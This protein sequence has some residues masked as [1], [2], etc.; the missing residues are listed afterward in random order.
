ME[1]TQEEE[2]IGPA[3]PGQTGQAHNTVANMC[4]LHFLHVKF[5]P[6]LKVQ[7]FIV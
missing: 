4:E 7:S 2:N 6:P 1:M 5:P 3:I